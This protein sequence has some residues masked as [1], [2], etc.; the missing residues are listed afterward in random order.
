[1]IN[2]FTCGLWFV[3]HEPKRRGRYCGLED[4]VK[5]V[6]NQLIIN[7]YYFQYGALASSCT[8]K[9]VW[10]Q[11]KNRHSFALVNETD[12]RQLLNIYKWLPAGR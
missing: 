5:F 9:T 3:R 7:K 10:V 4:N 12:D 2:C 8:I 11:V 1:M 6:C